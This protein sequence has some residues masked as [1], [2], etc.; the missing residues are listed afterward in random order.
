VIW[1]HSRSLAGQ[2]GISSPVSLLAGLLA[3]LFSHLSCW[4]LHPV[5]GHSPIVFFFG[6]FYKF[7]LKKTFF[8]LFEERPKMAMTK[9]LILALVASSC[10]IACVVVRYFVTACLIVFDY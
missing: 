1:T 6:T 10:L 7:F 8:C 5:F 9:A 2:Q 4:G 3:G